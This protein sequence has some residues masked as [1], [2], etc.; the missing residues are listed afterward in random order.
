MTHDQQVPQF[1]G[2]TRREMIWQTGAGFAGIA[3]TALLDGDNF[4]SGL[5]GNRAGAATV[6]AAGTPSPAAGIDLLAPRIVH[7][8]TKVKSCIFLFMYGGPSQVDM[9]DYKPELQKNDGKTIDMEM[10]RGSV[11]SK[12]CS[13]SKRTFKQH[14]KSGLWCSDAMPHLSAAHGRT[15]GHQEPLCRLVRARLGDD[16]DEQRPHHPGPSVDRLL[17]GLRPGDDE[18]EPAGLRGHARSPRRADQRRRQLVQ[19][20]HARRLSGNRVPLR[21]ASPF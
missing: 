6:A 15:G 1:C 9:F 10:R 16:P 17:A 3:L 7:I 18:S 21:P 12:S 13:A 2:R 20:L 11:R 14:G 19:R 4:F 8:P 5:F